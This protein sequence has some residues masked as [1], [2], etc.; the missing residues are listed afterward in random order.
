MNIDKNANTA[1]TPPPQR[2]IGQQYAQLVDEISTLTN[3]WHSLK[4][5]I[6]PVLG[7]PTGVKTDDT[8]KNPQPSMSPVAT[9]IRTIRYQLR[10]LRIDMQEAFDRV[11]L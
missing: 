6:E 5:D 4:S 11:E 9:D 2:E 8:T 10:D 7:P 3:V 1:T